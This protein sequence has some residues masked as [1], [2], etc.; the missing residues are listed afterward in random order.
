MKMDKIDWNKHG[1]RVTSPYGWRN[2]PFTGSKS[3]HTGIDLVKSHQAPI[4]AFAAGEV[5]H[6][7]MGQ[8]GT[9]FGGFGNVVAVKGASGH[10]HCYAHLDSVTVKVGDKVAQG[11]EVGRQGT[12]GRSTGSHLHYEVRSVS[13][14]SFGFGKDINPVDYLA[15]CTTHA[16]QKENKQPLTPKYKKVP[17]FVNGKALGEG[18]LLSGVT[19]IPLREYC[20]RLGGSI[21]TQGK[22]VYV[23]HKKVSDPL[24]INGST[25]VPVR[26]LAKYLDVTIN[27]TGKEVTIT[28]KK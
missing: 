17:V 11:Q 6:A 22:E 14:P 18:L 26:T 15:T 23:N 12:T 19:Y 1:F 8:P 4:Y 28:T 3:W 7:K 5:V 24:M 27:W 20:N 25:Y 16:Q 13:S 10:L 9:G 2:D 21:S